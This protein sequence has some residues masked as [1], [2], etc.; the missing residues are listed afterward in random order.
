VMAHQHTK[1]QK[2]EVE[3]QWSSPPAGTHLKSLREH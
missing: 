2:Q 1:W 3:W